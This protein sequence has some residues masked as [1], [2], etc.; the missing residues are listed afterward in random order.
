MLKKIY[1]LL[2]LIPFQ[3]FGQIPDYYIGIDFTQNGEN[4]KNQL[5]NLIIATH[6]NDLS[7][8]PGVWNAIK[9][10]DLDPD[11]PNDVLLI[12]GFDDSSSDVTEHRTRDVDL[13]C[14]SSNCNGKWVREHTYPRS[15]GNPNLGSSGPGSDVHHIRASD[16]QRNNLRSNRP[17]AEGS[18]PASYVTPTGL[19]Y[20][21]EEWEGNVARMMMYMYL[22]Y[23]DQCE[24][25]VVGSGAN[26]YHTDMPDLFLKWN[27]ENPVTEVEWVRN[28]VLED[29]QGNRNPFIDNPYLA[30]KIWGGPEAENTWTELSTIEAEELNTQVYPN[31]AN[32]ELNIKSNKK[33]QAIS[34]YLLTGSQ[35]FTQKT[36]TEDQLDVSNLPNGTY[37]LLIYY[38]DFTKE[39]KKIVIKK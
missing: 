12:Y 21:G 16:S 35:V 26:T 34:L 1:W 29:I 8:T 37:L 3:L 2:L 32:E 20:P 38:E 22:R 19:F 9:E 7:Y 13:S 27:A 18:G 31:P 5:S 28:M 17:F 11:N 14:H 36:L 4:L 24:A 33:I 30:T 10:T 25:N 23:G 39:S 6:S 15:L